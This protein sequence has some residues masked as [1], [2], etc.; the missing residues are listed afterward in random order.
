MTALVRAVIAE[1]FNCK[2]RTRPIGDRPASDPHR[3]SNIGL[4]R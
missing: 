1:A 4:V 3:E 2:R